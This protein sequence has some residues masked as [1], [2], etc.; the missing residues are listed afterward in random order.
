MIPGPFGFYRALT[1][2]LT[3]LSLCLMTGVAFGADEP[4]QPEEAT[5]GPDRFDQTNPVERKKREREIAER[6]RKILAGIEGREGSGSGGGS[7][8]SGGG[9]AGSGP[10]AK[11]GNPGDR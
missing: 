8:G 9:S 1:S 6:V 3:I 4:A 2:G 10:D 7:G 11:T 5:S